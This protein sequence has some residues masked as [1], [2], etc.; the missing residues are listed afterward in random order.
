MLREKNAIVSSK[1]KFPVNESKTCVSCGKKHG[2][3]IVE[4]V[5]I[6]FPVAKRLEHLR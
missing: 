5:K 4:V 6:A 1:T 3:I 2:K